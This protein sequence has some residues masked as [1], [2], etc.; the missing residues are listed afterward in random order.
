MACY[1]G[2]NTITVWVTLCV[3]SW[4]LPEGGTVG[5][6]KR[7]EIYRITVTDR[8]GN[9]LVAYCL[10]AVKQSYARAMAEEY[11]NIAIY[12]MQRSEVPADVT[13]IYG[14]SV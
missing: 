2:C 7:A 3:L 12:G 14:E 13:N 5:M 9:E 10:P 8:E 1:S 4:G 11:G 6:L